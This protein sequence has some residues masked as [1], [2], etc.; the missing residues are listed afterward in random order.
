[1]RGY[2]SLYSL[3]YNFFFFIF[4]IVSNVFNINTNRRYSFFFFYKYK[5]IEFYN[6][7]FFFFLDK[8]YLIIFKKSNKVRFRVNYRLEQTS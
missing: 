3:K 7:F 6:N 5:F 1:M 4:K 2:F 8:V